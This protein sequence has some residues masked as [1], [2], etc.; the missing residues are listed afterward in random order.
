M[1]AISCARLTR[2]AKKALLMVVM[3]LAMSSVLSSTSAQSLPSPS[4]TVFKCDVGGKVTYSDSPCLGAQ[5]IDLEPT[6]GV[7]KLSGAERIGADVRRE[8]NRELIAEAIRPITGKDA[9]QL[10]ILGRRMKLSPEAQRECQQLDTVIPAAEVREK[11][12]T[13]TALHD[14]QVEI[15]KMRTRFR[16]L[17]C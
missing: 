7:S 13:G 12:S 10:D 5:K 14:A 9:K 2:R 16:E 11:A 1:H 6:R 4:R 17:H 8:Q 3:A 15:Y